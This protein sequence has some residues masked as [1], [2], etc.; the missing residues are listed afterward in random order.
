MRTWR[1]FTADHPKRSP[2]LSTK[3]VCLTRRCYVPDVS[4]YEEIGEERLRAVIDEFVD[5]MF[6]D[7]MIGFFFRKASKARIK[8]MELQHAAAHPV[9]RPGAKSEVRA[10]AVLADVLLELARRRRVGADVLDDVALQISYEP[11]DWLLQ[12]RRRVLLIDEQVVDEF[13]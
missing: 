3:G 7:L 2:R 6:D 13:E 1:G 9:P 4:D 10:R 5:R 12:P 11:V 8:E